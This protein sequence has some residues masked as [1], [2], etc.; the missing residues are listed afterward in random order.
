MGQPKD[1]QNAPRKKDIKKERPRIDVGLTLEERLRDCGEPAIGLQYITEFSN[2]RDKRDHKM[3]TCKLEGCKSA[4]GTSDDIYNHV[5][6]H[7][8]QKNFFKVIVLIIQW[9]LICIHTNL[10]KE[11]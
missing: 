5:K 11:P 9:E 4:W 1:P 10:E 8:H 3:Y 7:K 6:N 2:P